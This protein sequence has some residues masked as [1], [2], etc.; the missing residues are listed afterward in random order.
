MTIQQ[1][2]AE[3]SEVPLN[4]VSLLLSLLIVFVSLLQNAENLLHVIII[5]NS[6]LEPALFALHSFLVP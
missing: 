4:F 1:V 3:T 2:L 6:E 5:D